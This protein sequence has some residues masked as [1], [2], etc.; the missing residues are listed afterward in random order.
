MPQGNEEPPKTYYPTDTK[1][2]RYKRSLDIWQV[3]QTRIKQTLTIEDTI[4]TKRGAYIEFFVE[5]KTSEEAYDKIQ[6]IRKI[7]GLDDNIQFRRLS[8]CEIIGVEQ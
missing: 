8:V 2:L 4:D 3:I 1:E 5:A 7:M 6:K